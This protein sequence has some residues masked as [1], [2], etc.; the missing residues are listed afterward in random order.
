M[1]VCIKV[2]DCVEAVCSLR[3]GQVQIYPNH[4]GEVQISP[5]SQKFNLNAGKILTK[6]CISL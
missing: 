5:K 6:H 3:C 2:R 4:I 1:H